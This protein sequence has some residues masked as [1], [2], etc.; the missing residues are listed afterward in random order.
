[1][2]VLLLVAQL[3]Y[4]LALHPQSQ[5]REP[6]EIRSP[7]NQVFQTMDQLPKCQLGAQ[8]G[9]WGQ[10]GLGSN[11][12]FHHSLALRPRTGHLPSVRVIYSLWASVSSSVKEGCLEVSAR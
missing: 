12:S 6:R 9:F 1:M 7:W 3:P 5:P 10:V 11:F 4:R 2:Y 8:D